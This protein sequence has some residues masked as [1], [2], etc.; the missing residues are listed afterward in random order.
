MSFP[1]VEFK[2]CW[3]HFPVPISFLQQLVEFVYQGSLKPHMIEIAD[4]ILVL[5]K[6]YDFPSL[7]TAS[8]N[9]IHSLE[10]TTTILF[11]FGKARMK[12]VK[13]NFV[14]M[15]PRNVDFTGVR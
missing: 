6:I 4:K 13:Q 10:I 14:E 11:I 2:N 8:L 7:R 12:Q 3:L 5:S 1:G 9:S 15:L